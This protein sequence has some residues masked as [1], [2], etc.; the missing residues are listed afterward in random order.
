[1]DKSKI[2]NPIGLRVEFLEKYKNAPSP[3]KNEL[4]QF[5]YYRTYSRPVPAENRREDWWET[6]KRVVEFNMDLQLFAMQRQG[7]ELTAE[8]RQSLAKEAELMYDLMFNLKLFPSGRTL[9]VGGSPSSYKYP[10]SN[11]NCSFVTID[12]LNKFSEIFFVLMLGT[13]VGLSV[14]RKYVDLLPKVNTKIKIIHKEYEGIRP[15]RRNEHTSLINLPSNKRLEIIIGDSK[16]GWAEAIKLY[17]DIISSKQYSDIESII[18][19]YDNVR[20]A[21]ERLKTF[22]G[23]ASGHSAIE[24]MFAKMHKIITKNAESQEWYKLKPIDALDFATIIAENVVSGGTRRS[25]EIVFCDPDEK[26]VLE[27]KSNIYTNVN[28]QWVANDAILHRFLSNNT[29]FYNER[30]SKEDLDAHF[31][32]MRHSG[33]PKLFCWAI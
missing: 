19:N 33:E 15:E 13:G 22:G 6:I 20:P 10:L 16:S 5:V 28:G 18:F 12:S 32:T 14:E 9:W 29:V 17:F 7:I 31:E 11:F 24:Q 1:M 4:G 21:G 2:A 8:I 23:Y 30:P 26:E 27:A 3:F 25:A